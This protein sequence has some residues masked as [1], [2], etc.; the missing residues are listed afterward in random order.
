MKLIYVYMIVST[1]MRLG[2]HW[3][4]QRNFDCSSQTLRIQGNKSLMHIKSTRKISQPGYFN[5]YP[6]ERASHLQIAIAW[7]IE[8]VSQRMKIE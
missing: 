2:L 4:P 3:R 1:S 7:L 5:P 6:I 8:E